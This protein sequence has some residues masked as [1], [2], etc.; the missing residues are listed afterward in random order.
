MHNVLTLPPKC[1]F[2]F[3]FCKMIEVTVSFYY[4]STKHW[5]CEKVMINYTYNHSAYTV[6]LI[7][8]I[9]DY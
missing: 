2:V 8:T 9:K 5:H 7:N 1:S 6:N 3:C 4:K